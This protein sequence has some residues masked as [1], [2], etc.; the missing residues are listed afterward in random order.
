M[1]ILEAGKNTFYRFKNNPCINWR[2]IVKSCN[3]ALFKQIEVAAAQGEG[4]AKCLIIDDTD[5]E[6][7]TYKS[8]HVGKIWSHV[9]HGHILGLKGLFLGIGTAKVFSR[10]I[11]ACTKKKA[12][13]KRNPLG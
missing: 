6:K 2:S 13:T 10:W 8:E 4:S 7:S 11:L 5:F 12:K 9:K 3:R 1:G